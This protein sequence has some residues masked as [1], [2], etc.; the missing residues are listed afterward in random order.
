VA[1][2]PT[3]DATAV[4]GRSNGTNDI[5]QAAIRPAG[6]SWSAPQ[7]LSATGQNAEEPAV[8]VDAVGD[9]VAVWSRFDGTHFIV[10]AA[11]RPANGLFSA[12]Q[13]LSQSGQD[14]VRQHV[15]V[16]ANGDAFVDWRRFDGTNYIV[17]AAVRPAGGAWGAAQDLSAAGQTALQPDIAADARGDAV[18]VWKR[19]DGTNF[20][21]QAAALPMGGSW[22][23]AQ[24]LSTAGQNASDPRIALDPFGDAVAD[25]NR[26]N[27]T[28][29]IVQAAGY[30]AAGPELN[31][32]TVPSQGQA[33]TP[34]ALSVSPFDI[35]S[36]V[37]STSWSWGDGSA[38]TAGTSVTHTYAAPGTYQI[39]VTSTDH[40]GNTTSAQR[41][42]TVA[43]AHGAPPLPPVVTK[44]TLVSGPTP[45]PTGVSFLLACKAAVGVVCRG[46][47]QLT[48]L[49]H[50]LG[51]RILALSASAR[52][53]SNRVLVGSKSFALAAGAQQKIVVA[54]NATG[55]RLLARF[56]RIPTTLRIKLLNTK[57]P[58]VITTKTTIKAKKKKK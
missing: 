1:L 31:M 2:D 17:Q 13:D 23:A 25:W 10:Q 21:V 26:F 55:R 18:A 40:V 27:G 15:A 43:A 32:L 42:I 38:A 50:L 24:S 14:A 56:G 34:V 35:W 6:G 37:A 30:D 5:I 49:E 45:S 44:F 8:G 33:G 19:S 54:L 52:R 39:T 20:I 57:P 29:D 3:G 51:L 22:G 7:D 9:A 16:D 36:A 58:T 46:L 47:A 53:H 28:N 11:T 41:T 12:P 48:T 4:W